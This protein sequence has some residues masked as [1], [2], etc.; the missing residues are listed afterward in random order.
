MKGRRMRRISVAGLLVG[1]T[2]AMTLAGLGVAS[3][4]TT[5]VTLTV[6]GTT[7]SLHATGGTV[8]DVLDSRGVTVGSGDYLTP[9][10]NTP[11][12][13]GT[14]IE[15]SHA[16]TLTATIDGQTK[17]IVT[18]ANTLSNALTSIGVNPSAAEL[19]VPAQ[20]QISPNDAVTVQTQK[21]V[22]VRADGNTAY[23]LTTA[24]TVA[25]VLAARGLTVGD[26]DRLNPAADTPVTDDLAITLQRVV[27]TRQTVTVDIPFNTVSQATPSL[28]KD[29]TKIVTPGV[30]G[31]AS[32]VVD[33]VTVDGVEESRTVVSSTTVTAPV[34]Q[35]QQ[36]G[37]GSYLGA[38]TPDAAAAQAIAQQ[39][40]TAQGMGDDQFQC[41]VS[42]WNHESHW[43]VASENTHSG[44]YGIPQALPGSKMASAGADWQTNPA[45]QIT[46]GLGYIDKRYGSP[47][48]AWGHFQSNGWY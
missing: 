5:D 38:T 2:S 36:V 39:M 29:Q 45:T 30:N 11:V 40:L 12:T 17:T 14:Q 9:S 41:L 21:M 27:T 18:T 22:S 4:A 19:S 15:V 31:Q 10:A 43:N 7:T 44:A 8:A 46:W 1:I 42:L 6:D 16:R 48:G 35:V 3:A 47:C 28:A 13:D 20:S 32:Q 23:F 26:A 34:D 33:I 25:D 37:L 24:N